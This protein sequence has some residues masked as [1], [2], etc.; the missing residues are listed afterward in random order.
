MRPQQ[1]LLRHV[2]QSLRPSMG[3]A[4]A[5]SA[6]AS[7]PLSLVLA[8]M[9]SSL[10]SFPALAQSDEGSEQWAVPT[11]IADA[12]RNKTNTSNYHAATSGA[13][14]SSSANAA[15]ASY[16]AS[17]NH[18]GTAASAN[19]SSSSFSS[20]SSSPAAGRS[21]AGYAAVEDFAQAVEGRDEGLRS[22]GSLDAAMG[23]NP[24]PSDLSAP[25]HQQ[26]LR[27]DLSEVDSEHT[28][29]VKAAPNLGSERNK[30]RQT[31]VPY[32][33]EDTHDGLNLKHAERDSFKKGAAREAL[34]AVKAPL[35]SSDAATSSPAPAPKESHRL[36]DG[37]STRLE[38]TSTP[39]HRAQG[40]VSPASSIPEAYAEV[41]AA[42]TADLSA[43]A[44]PV[45][46]AAEKA[47]KEPS[48]NS[49]AS[50][51]T[52]LIHEPTLAK[53]VDVILTGKGAGTKVEDR[54][55]ASFS[56]SSSTTT[57]S[58]SSPYAPS[59]CAVT[60]AESMTA[61]LSWESRADAKRSA[62]DASSHPVVSVNNGPETIKYV[63]GIK[64][65]Q[66]FKAFNIV[67]PSLVK[68]SKTSFFQDYLHSDLNRESAALAPL[69]QDSDIKPYKHVNRNPAI[70]KLWASKGSIH[71]DALGISSS[72]AYWAKEYTLA[73]SQVAYIGDTSSTQAS[74][75]R[76]GFDD[77][78]LGFEDVDGYTVASIIDSREI[79]DFFFRN[80]L[81]AKSAAAGQNAVAEDVEP[82][83]D[84]PDTES[85]DL[86]TIPA[87]EE[88]GTTTENTGTEEQSVSADAELEEST[89]TAE[90]SA[91]AAL[92]ATTPSNALRA[93]AA[94]E[95]SDLSQLPPAAPT[96]TGMSAYATASAIE[97][98]TIAASDLATPE[99]AATTQ[100]VAA[101]SPNGQKALNADQSDKDRELA[102]AG[103]SS[104]AEQGLGSSSYGHG[105]V[106]RV[107][108]ES[109]D[110]SSLQDVLAYRKQ[111]L[112]TREQQEAE[113]GRSASYRHSKRFAHCPMGKQWKIAVLQLGTSYDYDEMFYQT[114][115]GL[116]HKGLIDT[117]K[118][119]YTRAL[120]LENYTRQQKSALEYIVQQR[121][122]FLGSHAL[123]G[124]EAASYAQEETLAPPAIINSSTPIEEIHYVRDDMQV[125]YPGHILENSK[126][127]PYTLFPVLPNPDM[128]G[129][130]KITLD[131]FP[132]WS[133]L[134]RY[135]VSNGYFIPPKLNFTYPNNYA[136]YV[137]LT[138]D[139]CFSLQDDGYYFSRWDLKL[140]QH[141]L[142]TLSERAQKGEIDMIL[143]FGIYDISWVH[144]QKFQIP[145]VVV[146]HDPD[147]LYNHIVSACDPFYEQQLRLQGLTPQSAIC[148]DVGDLKQSI[149]MGLGGKDERNSLLNTNNQHHGQSQEATP[150]SNT[151]HASSN[152]DA[153][154]EG[155]S[156]EE[157]LEDSTADLIQVTS[158]HWERPEKC[159]TKPQSNSDEELESVEAETASEQ[160]LI[161]PEDDFLIAPEIKALREAVPSA[162]NAPSD[163]TE[164]IAGAN[165][166]Y[167][168]GQA[169]IAVLDAVEVESYEEEDTTAPSQGAGAATVE[170][171]TDADAANSGSTENSASLSTLSSVSAVAYASANAAAVAG[172]SAFDALASNAEALVSAQD[173]SLLAAN[174]ITEG[175]DG[176]SASDEGRRS[177]LSTID[178]SENIFEYEVE[179][180]EEVGS[181][182][183]HRHYYSG[184]VHE[185]EDATTS[186]DDDAIA[187]PET[188]AAL[189][190]KEDNGEINELEEVINPKVIAGI[191]AAYSDAN[192]SS[193]FGGTCMLNPMANKPSFTLYEYSPYPNIHVQLNPIRH[194][195]DVE[196]Y[197]QIFKFKRL[198][199]IADNS[200][201]YPSMHS[202]KELEDLMRSLGG[203]TL[204]CQS[205]FITPD[206]ESA[207]HDFE[208]CAALLAEDN[209]DAVYLMRNNGSTIHK[210]YRQLRPLILK[211]I[212]V[213]S[214]AGRAEVKSGALMSRAYGYEQSFGRFESNVISQIMHGVDPTHISQYFFPRTLLTV[215]ARIATEIEWIPSYIDLLR[216]DVTYLDVVSR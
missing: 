118:I 63:S 93:S 175:E 108:G 30:H 158:P 19:S 179:E 79:R 45:G 54:D 6:R 85:I 172:A 75:I 94:A 152:A 124:K 50:S 70:K 44:I 60:P 57:A 208:R 21:S 117:S 81:N 125:R 121:H 177:L 163:L 122:G 151:I 140:H 137:E 142:A 15:A 153:D 141:Q 18:A 193:Y 103:A 82:S 89:A 205:R 174:D 187:I 136:Y 87:P 119:D 178:L 206:E 7:V 38:A 69:A 166:K 98:G 114:L 29:V 113:A 4:A 133:D 131:D 32:D 165:T 195:D 183:Y 146:G 190:V 111:V 86:S 189:A 73:A 155:N 59:K 128:N 10:L 145:V 14:E 115:V 184:V 62:A 201:I 47:E 71:S 51:S 160:Q 214:R 52:A 35:A 36:D 197:Q 99:P 130:G 55:E 123:L 26:S 61:A 180:V 181:K 27:V 8:L 200:E 188:E 2:K 204:V 161:S 96:A 144:A 11:S 127:Y 25:E 149:S 150:A 49:S 66:Q 91:T 167:A 48:S 83:K 56:A 34:E 170:A 143:V 132:Q 100:D 202:V 156:L 28:P 185:D 76:A 72:N 23:N 203:S 33:M 43:V 134:T 31:L 95:A 120:A 102:P 88:S 194:F 107:S 129:D 199:I 12:A 16:Y 116:I 9:V 135:G 196:Y 64:D 104:D 171:D 74:S 162:S 101:S 164:N 1:S 207:S 41:A 42:V 106:D 105:K 211:D 13:L 182:R 92:D 159:I 213:F 77:Q 191:N 138:R 192:P 148:G 65:P 126:L 22:M 169:L 90:I 139:S 173:G 84:A 37:D 154:D 157:A 198:G 186:Q 209:V 17:V 109:V 110:P 176:S 40:D 112:E 212:P 215:N 97:S 46:D 80:Q 210:L 168:V 39:E 58:S 3:V 24:H 67:D 20:S 68:R 5:L 216:I 53:G 147:I 78:V